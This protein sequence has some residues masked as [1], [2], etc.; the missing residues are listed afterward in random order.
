M[1]LAQLI[2]YFETSPAMRLL[3]SPNAPFIV[4][5]LYRQFKERGRLT[6]PMSELLVGLSEYREDLH[7]TY[8]EALRDKPEQYISAWCAGD[9][10]WLHRFLEAKSNEPVYQLTPHTEDV[11][12]FLD[13]A[14]QKDLGFV[15]T[16]SRLRLVISTLADLVAGASD[17]PEVHLRHLRQERAR[18][19]AEITQVERD[20]VTTRY[21]PA[22][23]RE[24][25]ATAVVLLKQLM[26]DFRDVEDRFRE[27]TKD[28]QRRQT[29]G[30]DPRGS[31]L[32]YALDSEDLLKKEDQGVSFYEF[33]RFILSPVQQEKLQAIITELGRLEAIAQQTDGLATVQRMVP[34]LLA[35]AEKVMRTNQRLSATLRRL[36]DSHSAADR[37]RLAQLLM[38]IRSLAAARA[39]SPPDES[40]GVE[41]D[42]GIA[43]ALPLSRAFW[44]AAATFATLDLTE[45]AAD[46][47]KRLEAFRLLAGMHRLDWRSMRQRISE[48]VGMH[49]TAT[50]GQ[51]IEN[52]PPQV[53]VV[54]LLAYLQIARDEGHLISK[55]NVEQ[56]C[57][58]AQD[59]SQ[60]D[61]HVTIP[62]VYFTASPG[63][64]EAHA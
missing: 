56:V 14:L 39:D 25:F 16:E 27:I 36:L 62:L 8:P 49:G 54:E 59:P 57:L 22:A 37:Q 5:F 48:V 13:R 53:G 45:H 32:E 61:L 7:G 33:V 11:F 15:G 30:R 12:L 19:D 2:S 40:L 21:E 26:A 60:R 28:V 51:I 41:I 18:I 58:R 10:R 64:K 20:G 29:Q 31:I 24:R 3:R 35:E 47:E 44:S 42:T 6:I 23:I 55:Q 17:D 52:Y 1:R 4:D 63:T 9:S 50:I 34:L 46:D 43:L 38:E